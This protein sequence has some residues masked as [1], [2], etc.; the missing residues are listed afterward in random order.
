M[1]IKLK[2]QV[3]EILEVL[4]KKNT[5][6][7]ASELANE[8]KID[9]IVLMT[10]INDLI[11]ENLGGFREEE[12]NQIVL[13]DEG[14]IYLKKGLPERQLLKI[15]LD[16]N[17]KE[18]SVEDLQVKSKLDKQIFYVGI[19]NMKKNRWVAQ[20][21]A[22][23]ENKIFLVN[24]EFP[25]TEIEKFLSKFKEKSTI[26]YSTLSKKESTYIDLLNKRKLI[27]KEKK[28]LRKIFL[29]TKGKALKISDVEELEQVSK[30]TSE[31]LSS[32][33]W[34]NYNLKPFDITKPG[35]SLK[36]GKTHPLVNLINEIREIFISMGFTEI[37]GPIVESAFFNFDALFQPQ[38]HPARELQD[39]FYLNNPKVARLPNKDR[40]MAVKATHENGG[41]SGSLGWRYKWDENIAKQTVLRTHTTAT[42]MRR[43][44]QFYNDNEKTPIKVFCIDRVFRNEKLDKSHLAEFT[45]VEGIVI[46]ENVNLS[47]LIGLLSEFYR[48][49]GFKKIVTRPG[50]FPYTE[51]SMEVSVYYD[52]LGEWLEMGGSGIFRPEVT[53]PWGIKNPTRVL[54]WGQGLERIAMPYYGRKDIRDLYVNPIKWLRQQPY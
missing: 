36:A 38:D 29:T 32:G 40:V 43:L 1:T 53:S 52:K 41:D 13:N 21:K 50:F 48:K 25:E 44:A 54:A 10:A 12:V 23:G 47:D 5:E 18:I 31:M 27:V 9:Y 16:S 2:K 34:K 8:L 3:I 42:T 26:N 39:T 7:L 33:T 45:Q 37:R 30:I 35:P 24:E 17:I 20:S 4:K 22:S 19:S 49:M 46:D 51:P 11:E 28:T 14:T 15:I 6:L